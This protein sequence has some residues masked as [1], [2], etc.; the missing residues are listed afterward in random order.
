MTDGAHFRLVHSRG[1]ALRLEPGTIVGGADATLTLEIVAAPAATEAGKRFSHVGPGVT[2]ALR[3][4]DRPRLPRLLRGQLMLVQVDERARVIRATA[5]QQAGALDALYA[6][7]EALTDLGASVRPGRTEFRLWAPT[8]QDVAL[9]VYARGDAPA[10]TVRAMQ[11]DPRTGVWRAQQRAD[12]SGQY[13]TYLVEV[14]V[15]GVGVVRN[16]VTDPYSVSLTTDSRRSLVADLNDGALKPAGW[17]RATR[18][19][20]LAAQTDLVVYELHVRDF[21][22]DDDSPEHRGTYLAFTESDTDGMRH[23]Q[24]LSQGR[25]HRCASAADLRSRQRART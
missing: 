14:F 13:Y 20:P 12:L 6:A 1:A 23:L 22:R 7:A 5:L 21:S 16:Y 19:K 18:P 17:D 8:A 10:R 24:G 25:P 4:A 11:R 9:C 15:P 3:A 2:L